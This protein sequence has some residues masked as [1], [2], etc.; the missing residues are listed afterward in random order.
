MKSYKKCC[1]HCPGVLDVS[2]GGKTHECCLPKYVSGSERCDEAV[3]CYDR[4]DIAKKFHAENL[5]HQPLP[6]KVDYDA[7]RNMKMKES[8][9][10]PSLTER[11]RNSKIINDQSSSRFKHHYDSV[12]GCKKPETKMDLAICWQTPVDPTYEPPRPA[13]I[14]GSEGGAAPAIFELIQHNPN[15][16]RDRLKYN[17]HN[18]KCDDGKICESYPKKDLA[19]KYQDRCYDDLQ[20]NRT[21]GTQRCGCTNSRNFTK[22]KFSER[23]KSQYS[24]RN[25]AIHADKETSDPRLIRSA[26][27]IALG[28]ESNDN[29]YRRLPK[30]VDVPRPKTP[31]ARRSFSIETL[32][33]PFS[34]VNGCRDTDYP[35]HRRLMTVYQQSYKNPRRF[36]SNF[37]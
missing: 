2:K 7:L 24:I 28:T 17:D 31:F 8:L 5:K 1:A 20:A 23:S 35:E 22:G 37:H 27:G 13:H 14:D 11:R 4:F 19:V 33:P 12:L 10:L 6:D 21:N 29:A 36:R 34:I 30:Q 16:T 3:P 26:V 25:A 32:A 9:H 18:T 15:S